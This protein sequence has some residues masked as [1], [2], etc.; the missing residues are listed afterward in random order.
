MDEQ[1]VNVPRTIQDP[2]YRYTRP[3]MR[4][5]VEGRG[6]MI[7]TIILNLS[8]IAVD[9]YRT[10]EYI[11]RFFGFEL[12]ASTQIDTKE[13][14][15][16]KYVIIG[17]RTVD[18]LNNALDKFINNFVVC[19]T[20][21]KNPETVLSIKRGV[22]RFRCNACGYFTTPNAVHK[23][24]KFILNHPTP[25]IEV[26][27]EEPQKKGS[28][29][30]KQEKEPDDEWSVTTNADAVQTRQQDL[31][32][33]S[34]VLSG[35]DDKEDD[36]KAEPESVTDLVLPPGGNPLALLSKFWKS[37]PPKEL[38]EEKV[39][40]LQSDQEWSDVQ[41]FSVVFGSL[42]DQDL[43]KDFL[44]KA[45]IMSI[46]VKRAK[47]QKQLL[48][49]IEKLCQM[50]PALIP[51]LPAILQEFYNNCNLTED[52]V[53]DW[54]EEPSKKIPKNLAQQIRD[55]CLPFIT[56]LESAEV[57]EEEKEGAV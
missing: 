7:K 38:I 25:N 1:R 30:K 24:T 50:H 14:N 8:E 20:C 23:L 33:G 22:L 40:K 9:V 19:G 11:L 55:A 35:G 21:S 4:V 56:W 3:V 5:K 2:N 36:E 15:H 49:C 29:G 16:P 46:F 53:F 43:Q 42:F 51:K 34:A 45:E 12:G 47:D 44:G 32:G 17:H 10:P 52:V 41:L 31:S 18:E 28:K 39:H 54:Y 6:K 48:I 13:T 57:E 26:D 37:N 27:D